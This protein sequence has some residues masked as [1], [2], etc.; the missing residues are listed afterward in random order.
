MFCFPEKKKGETERHCSSVNS[1][2]SC[3]TKTLY[4][5][6]CWIRGLARGVKV[7][8]DTATLWL[9]R[10][11]DCNITC[12]ALW[13]SRKGSRCSDLVF[14]QHWHRSSL[15]SVLLLLR[16]VMMSPYTKY[17]F[18]MLFSLWLLLG[19]HLG[20]FLFFFQWMCLFIFMKGANNSGAGYILHWGF[21]NESFTCI[22]T[23]K[24][25]NLFV[26]KTQKSLS[27]EQNTKSL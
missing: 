27:S 20:C 12:F 11:H 7:T 13:F 4:T 18:I 1:K 5:P 23:N 8:S 2:W 25:Q 17:P 9:L 21:R 6:R 3:C 24:S 10:A 15:V 22:L 14:V 26:H 19:L 16:S